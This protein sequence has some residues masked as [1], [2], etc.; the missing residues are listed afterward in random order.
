MGKEVKCTHIVSQLK[1]IKK[2]EGY[3]F[4]AS[5][6]EVFIEVYDLNE[7]LAILGMETHMNIALSY[8]EDLIKLASK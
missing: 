2:Y 5:R 8:Y 3:T 7:C 6:G 4:R 1:N